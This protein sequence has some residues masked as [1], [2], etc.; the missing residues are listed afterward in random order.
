MA[1][2]QHRAHLT[3]AEGPQMHLTI[4]ADERVGEDDPAPASEGYWEADVTADLELDET[5]DVAS[6]GDRDEQHFSPA[7]GTRM[8]TGSTSHTRPRSS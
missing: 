2:V 3:W 8:A 4:Q 1:D 5:L 7:V 6:A